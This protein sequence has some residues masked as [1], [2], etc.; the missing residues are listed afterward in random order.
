MILWVALVLGSFIGSVGLVYAMTFVCRQLRW[1]DIP[2]ARSSHS[3]PTARIG[4]PGFILSWLLCFSVGILVSPL[5]V[6]RPIVVMIVATLAMAILGFWDDLYS[7]SPKRR[8]L[9]QILI[10]LAVFIG[11]IRLEA[12][13]LPGWVIHCSGLSV[14]LT[15]FFLVAMT[16]IYNFM[17]GIDGYAGGIGLFTA[18]AF[19]VFSLLSGGVVMG[20]LLLLLAAALAGFLVWNFPKARIF[21]GDSGSAALGF[22]FGTAMLFLSQPPF[23]QINLIA[24]GMCLSVFILDAAV[25]IVRRIINKERFWEAHRQ[26]CYQKL[27]K[28]GWSHK[29]VIRLEYAHILFSIGCAFAYQ[30]ASGLMQWGILIGLVMTFFCKFFWVNTRFKAC[31]PNG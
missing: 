24:L 26:H 22:L 9:I 19:S 27:V 4:A 12:I 10:A 1:L 5:F 2:N 21:M 16:N 8:F 14:F 28:L 31:F 25:V 29:Q 23:G 6:T 3:I 15:V 20:M 18:L 17:D 30:W 11:G 13:P 7:L